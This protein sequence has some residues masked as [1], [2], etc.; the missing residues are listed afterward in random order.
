M[1]YLREL[2][3]I[4]SIY[5]FSDFISNSLDL[6]LPGN[7]LGMLLLLLMLITGVIKVTQVE[8]IAN[9]FLEHLSFFFIPAGVGLISSMETLKSSFIEIIFICIVTTL[10]IMVITGKTV[11]LIQRLST[12]EEK[13]NDRNN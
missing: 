4:I 8:S 5:L 10:F 13:N 2:T 6:P 9:F 7:I 1:K 3:I 12:K 11:E